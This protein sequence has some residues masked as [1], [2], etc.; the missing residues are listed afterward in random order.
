MGSVGGEFLFRLEGFLQAVEHGVIGSCHAVELVASFPQSD[1]LPQV[2][3]SADPL[4]RSYDPSNRQKRPV[5]DQISHR[6]AYQKKKRQDD[7]RIMES[8]SLSPCTEGTMPLR[9]SPCR[10][11][12]ERALS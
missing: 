9:K 5:R 10:S 4:R 1:P 11:S 7:Q 8:S 12:P 2:I 3:A 6:Q